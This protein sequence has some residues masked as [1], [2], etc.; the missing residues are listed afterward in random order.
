MSTRRRVLLLV[1]IVVMTITGGVYL[2]NQANRQTIETEGLDGKELDN[3]SKDMEDLIK[4]LERLIAQ[5]DMNIETL[6][7]LPQPTNGVTKS[8]HDDGY[9]NSFIKKIDKKKELVVV[10]TVDS[11]IMITFKPTKENF[12]KFNL[13]WLAPVTFKCTM[14]KDKK[15]DFNLPFKPLFILNGPIEVEELKIL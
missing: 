12:P 10:I 4:E 2:N 8:Y 5:A 11:K 3:L 6:Q 13:G 7:R 15:C 9:E 14:K 1:L